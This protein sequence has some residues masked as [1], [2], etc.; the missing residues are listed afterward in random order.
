MT[1]QQVN[2]DRPEQLAS[3]ADEIYSALARRFPVCLASDE[4][5]YFPH[6]SETRPDWSSWD[7]FSP[8]AIDAFFTQVSNWQG[9][10]QGLRPLQPSSAM[11]VDL[12][13]LS[14]VLATLVE[15]L[16]L[17]RPHK[18]QPT[19]YLSIA[20][21]G[22]AEALDHSP[23]AFSQRCETLPKFM[24]K[25]IANLNQ[26]PV[27]FRDL[28]AEMTSKLES[29]LG[30]LRPESAAL[31]AA[32]AAMGQMVQ[33]LKQCTTI[34][35][36]R[37]DSDLYAHVAERHMGCQ[38]GLDEIEWHLDQEIDETRDLLQQEAARITPATSWREV[39]A[40]LPVPTTLTN[41]LGASYQAIISQLKDHCLAHGFVAP[42]MVT[43]CP[44]RVQTIPDH[45]LPIR[46]NAAYS[47][48]PGYPP[49]G[50]TF[51]TMPGNDD[52]L[53]RDIM[54]L[55]AHETFPGHHLLDTLRWR[56][57]RPI[58]R[59][60]E[61][62]IFYEG[63]ASIAEEIL[64]DTHFFSGPVDRL[65]M[66]KRRYWRA[67]RGRIDLKLHTHRHGV[68][69]AAASLSAKGIAPDR[70]TAMVRRYALKP[71]YQLAYTIGRRKF[72]QLYAIYLSNGRTPTQFVQQ[73]LSQGEIG[74]DHLAEVLLY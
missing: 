7:D 61:F 12:E 18:T 4:F 33:H 34:P 2:R 38:M 50:G 52:D 30:Q 66:A 20:S 13:M 55:A 63:W 24:Q 5:H 40:A 17:A 47:M 32:I 51:Y 15:Q 19:F 69:D 68:E 42:E 26:V 31:S 43:D 44:V 41:G 64:F 37:L 49:R 22:L 21:I 6:Y 60:I 57:D 23:D 25:A 46:S 59:C 27:L 48:P 39:L 10:I 67:Q 16:R 58:R 72:R 1:T 53:P 70:A 54:L 62:P 29:W 73:A 28:G 14:Q 74:F 11:G 71:G 35:E 9:Q 56:L 36:F 8:D 65:L 45:L 3:L